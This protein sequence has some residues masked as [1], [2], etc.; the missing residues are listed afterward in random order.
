MVRIRRYWLV[1]VVELPVLQDRQEQSTKKPQALKPRVIESPM[2]AI[3]F[4]GGPAAAAAGVGTPTRT[5]APA[6]VASTTETGR[7]RYIGGT[8]CSGVGPGSPATDE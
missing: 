1:N 8:S 2:L 7:G 5:N 6:A 3:E 4:G